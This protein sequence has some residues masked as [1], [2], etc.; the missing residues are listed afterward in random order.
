MDCGSAAVAGRIDRRQIV[1]DLLASHP[2]IRPDSEPIADMCKVLPHSGGKTQWVVHR[3]RTESIDYR[4]ERPASTNPEPHF[5]ISP[6]VTE[7]EREAHGVY[8]A[9]LDYDESYPDGWTFAP[10]RGS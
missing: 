10:P 4:R 2:Q 7:S 1:C 8:L 6:A 3:F 5:Q 9:R